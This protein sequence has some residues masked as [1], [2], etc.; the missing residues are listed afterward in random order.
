M[1]RVLVAAVLLVVFLGVAAVLEM[2]TYVLHRA[3]DAPRRGTASSERA[4]RARAAGDGVQELGASDDSEAET[5]SPPPPAAEEP[6]FTIH[7]KGSRVAMPQRVLEGRVEDAAGQPLAGVRVRLVSLWL[8]D[9][10][11]HRHQRA[12]GVGTGVVELDLP[13]GVAESR[14]RGDGTFR[15]RY[16]EGGDRTLVVGDDVRHAVAVRNPTVGTPCIVR[17]TDE[18][19]TLTVVVRRDE[20][21]RPIEGA[22][23]HVLRQ[24]D[25][26]IEGLP[27]PARAETGTDGSCRFERLP[28]GTVSVVAE[29]DGYARSAERQVLRR[30]S[31]VEIRLDTGYRLAGRLVDAETGR[32]VGGWLDAAAA[33]R[34][35]AGDDG[36]IIVDHAPAPGPRSFHTATATAAG[37]ADEKLLAGYVDDTRTCD[38]TFALQRPA[39][40][41]VRCV[42]PDGRPLPDVIVH[43]ITQWQAPPQTIGGVTVPRTVFDESRSADTD[44]EGRTTLDGLHPGSDGRDLTVRFYLDGVPVLERAFP[45]LAAREVRDLGDVVLALGPT[46]RGTVLDADGRPAAGVTVSAAPSAPDDERRSTVG[47]AQFGD[48]GRRAETDAAGRFTLV[49]LTPGLWDLYAARDFATPGTLRLGVDAGSGDVTI[50]LPRLVVLSGRVLDAQGAPAA[51]ACVS[52]V[53]EDA[54]GMRVSESVLCDAEGRFALDRFA[55]GAEDVDVEVAAKGSAAQTFRVRPGT[56]AELRLR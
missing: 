26:R 45:P 51:G 11:V 30:S 4:P 14:T 40:L 21:D 31:P 43:A 27:C 25:P 52:A 49:G 53:R 54:F 33:G 20:D 37:Y 12:R 28:E 2:R 17:L 35:R 42:A 56:P 19:E 34:V 22:Q 10:L 9:E 38:L 13:C 23:V 41:R 18:P 36:R 29:A 48:G 16:V 50:S 39:T 3:A 32:T 7:P 6:T 44:A 1:R 55:E 8:P 47:A 5:T 46:L 24:V 15:L